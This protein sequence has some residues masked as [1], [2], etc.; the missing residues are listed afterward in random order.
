M[1][2]HMQQT[3]EI[4]YFFRQ[5]TYFSVHNIGVHF[6]QVMLN[7]AHWFS[8]ADG[9]GSFAQLENFILHPSLHMK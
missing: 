7:A 9:S 1:N 3:H 2:N 6:P 4:T 8:G 5:P